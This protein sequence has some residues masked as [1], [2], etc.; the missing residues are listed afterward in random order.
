MC[1]YHT[2][3]LKVRFGCYNFPL[4]VYSY[5]PVISMVMFRPWKNL[6]KTS[7]L[8]IYQHSSRQMKEELYPADLKTATIYLRRAAGRIFDMAGNKN[9]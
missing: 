3:I 1:R 7:K 5:P 6:I 8:V 4:I 2:I 9:G